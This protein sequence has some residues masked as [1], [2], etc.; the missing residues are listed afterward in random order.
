MFVCSNS[1]AIDVIKAVLGSWD[2]GFFLS[3][4][5]VGTSNVKSS[6]LDI[7]DKYDFSDSFIFFSVLNV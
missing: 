4:G 5:P 6:D 1:T 3:R 2:V 7:F